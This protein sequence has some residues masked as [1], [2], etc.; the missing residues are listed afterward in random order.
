MNIPR[1][2]YFGH[3]AVVARSALLPNYLKGVTRFAATH[4]YFRGAVTIFAHRC[5]GVPQVF[6]RV[7]PNY[8]ERDASS[9]FMV[10]RS[11]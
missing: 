9:R 1:L 4:R 3:R 2:R 6:E 8:K 11:K 5:S 10:T 7:C